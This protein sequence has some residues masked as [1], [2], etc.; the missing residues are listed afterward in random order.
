M[1]PALLIPACRSSSFGATPT[2]DQSRSVGRYLQRP[3][4][5]VDSNNQIID[6][7]SWKMNQ[8]DVKFGFDFHRT[9]VQQYFDKYFRGSLQESDRLCRERLPPDFDFLAG[10]VTDGFQY[11]GDSTRHTFENNFGF[12]VQDSFRVTPRLTFNYGLRYDYFGVV[13][14]KNNLLSNITSVSPNPGSG[15]SLL[16]RSASPGSAVSTIRITTTSPRASALPGI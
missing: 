7:F 11:A 8:H 3:R 5:R 1:A 9:T 13:G 2:V 14:E 4:H 15:P 16:L 6:N 12:Y 10:D